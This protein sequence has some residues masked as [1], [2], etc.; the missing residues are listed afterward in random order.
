MGTLR[1][2]FAIA[3]VF[4]HTWAKG[5]VLVGGRNAVELFYVISGFLIS[6]VL[7]ERRGYPRVG[8]FYANRLLRLYPM[9][10]AVA[11]ATLALIIATRQA[12]FLDVYRDAPAAAVDLLVGSNLLLLGQDW[13]MFAGVDAGH[14][15]FTPDF[16]RSAI[17][18]WRGLLVPQAWTL[19]VELSFYL[20]A[21]FVLA[22][23][24]WLLALLALSLAIRAGLVVAG[25]GLHDPWSNRFFPAELSLFLLGA[26]AQQE[27]LPRYRRW[28][29][30]RE[31]GAASGATA[32]LVVACSLYFLVPVPE[33]VKTVALFALFIPLVPLTFM[34]QERHAADARIG[35]L[36][37]PIYIGHLLVIDLASYGFKAAGIVDPLAI[38]LACVVLAVG[39]AWVL[40]EGIG[41]PMERIRARVKR[42]GVAGTLTPAPLPRAGEGRT[43]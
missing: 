9:Y 17:E 10:A 3:V 12:G 36:S 8:A 41:R 32:F 40:D 29:A 20:I 21:P 28:F 15:V 39:F 26:L 1:T 11:L 13:V 14:L 25:L 43:L 2:L 42:G 6:Y 27:L 34:F 31:G 38:S 19:G 4:A 22:R 16:H 24:R 5:P 35:D 7:V 37:Y 18:L 33:I 23:R 30:G